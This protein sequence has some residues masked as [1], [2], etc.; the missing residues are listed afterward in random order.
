MIPEKKTV[1]VTVKAYP[2]PSTKYVETVCCAGVDLPT[3]EWLRLY[4][5]RYR[6]LEDNKR[7]LAQA[8]MLGEKRRL[9]LRGKYETVPNQLHGTGS[10]LPAT[11]K[12]TWAAAIAAPGKPMTGFNYYV[13][14]YIKYLIDNAGKHPDVALP[15]AQLLTP[16]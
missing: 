9:L 4:P 12:N 11:M 6:D 13:G 10:I 3:G 5:I 7:A 2:N 14:L 1:L 15:T 8:D 16:V